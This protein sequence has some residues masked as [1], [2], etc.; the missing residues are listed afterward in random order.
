M[1]TFH[2]THFRD[3]CFQTVDAL[4]ETTSPVTTV[5]KCVK[6]RP[7]LKNKMCKKICKK[8]KTKSPV[9]LAIGSAE[10]FVYQCEQ[11]QHIIEHRTVILIFPSLNTIICCLLSRRK[12]LCV[13]FE[14]DLAKAV[15]NQGDLHFGLYHS[16]FEW[17]H[18]LYKEDKA[19]NFQTRK[20]VQVACISF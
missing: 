2:L 19:N 5:R 6:V 12:I 7:Q 18:P 17:F 10:M 11:Q 16:L 20:F 15:R 14:G 1:F 4:V 8:S 9:T 3:K 13:L